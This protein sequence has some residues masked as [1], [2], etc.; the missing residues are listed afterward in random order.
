MTRRL[1]A[2]I[3][4]IAATTV[5]GAGAANG[6]VLHGIG[7]VHSSMGGAGVA[8]PTS[9]LAALHH[10]PALLPLLENVVEI[11]AEVI[12]ADN[13]VR[14]AIGPIGGSTEDLGDGAVIP[15][16]GAVYRPERGRWAVAGGFLGTA[17]FATNYPQD[18]SNPVLAPQPFGMGRAYGTYQLVR[19]PIAFGWQASDRLSIGAALNAGQ[20]TF[21]A[22]PAA[23]AG[24]DC[25]GA[26]RCF[27]PSV[28][29][30]TATGI[31]YTLGAVYRLGS[32]VA[33]GA[34]YVSEQEFEEFE[35]TTTVANPS[36]PSYGTRRDI[37]FQINPPSI[38]SVGVALT[39]ERLAIAADVKRMGYSDARG[40]GSPG[41]DPVTGQPRSLGWRDIEVF[42]LG[43]QYRLSERAVA[44]AGVNLG[45]NPIP[46]SASALNVLSPAVFEDHYAV[47]FGYRV[48]DAVDLDLAY[49]R[50][51]ESSVS[52]PLIGPSG[53]LSGTT[54][55]SSISAQA[56]LFTLSFAY[57]R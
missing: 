28:E 13:S 4:A 26:G 38:A 56:L 9:A 30:D 7:A 25:D 48:A 21:A 29:E 3:A 5:G 8:M 39:F 54:V 46:G 43:L 47:G 2:W 10:N 32:R 53:P 12:E 1:L 19:V 34:S 6:P 27:F 17:G 44:R 31:G 37:A 18:P 50:A 20:Q 35:W 42:A 14:S 45:E 51:T 55:E 41:P 22:S 24:P 33:A 36:L 52:G 57:G 23:F 49:Y 16:L 11:G 40:F 15:A